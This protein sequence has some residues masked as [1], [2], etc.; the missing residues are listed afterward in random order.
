MATPVFWDRHRI[1]QGGDPVENGLRS[2]CGGTF[3]N[4]TIPYEYSVCCPSGRPVSMYPPTW[5]H[6]RH[7]SSCAEGAGRLVAVSDDHDHPRRAEEEA[8]DDV[9]D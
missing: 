1:H 4:D 9:I 8:E 2:G 5:M 3:D 7:G 6:D